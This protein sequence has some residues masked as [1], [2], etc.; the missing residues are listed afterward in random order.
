MRALAR[1]SDLCADLA[2][3]ARPVRRRRARRTRL[4][5][6]WQLA[7]AVFEAQA[8]GLLASDVYTK[9]IA[10][11][12]LAQLRMSMRG[13]ARDRPTAWRRTCCSSAAT[14][15]RRRPGHPA[16]RLAAVRRP[17]AWTSSRTADY[18]AAALG[19]FDPAMVSQARKRVA[20]A[21]D[22]WSAVAGGEQH[23]LA[24]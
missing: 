20:A 5:T 18:E 7:A 6:F 24:G 15:G 17:G 13:Q 14:P 16:P 8:G 12:L 3:G 2:A 4:A 10:S 23:R 21:K 1:M 22:A 9:R 11:R 19:R